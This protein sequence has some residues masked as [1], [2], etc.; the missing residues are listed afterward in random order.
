MPPLTSDALFFL[1]RLTCASELLGQMD[2][3]CVAEKVQRI[4]SHVEKPHAVRGRW[5][6]Y[7]MPPL[8]S[9]ALSVALR[10]LRVGR[11]LKRSSLTSA[12]QSVPNMCSSREPRPPVS[13]AD[14]HLRRLPF[15]RPRLMV[16][17]RRLVGDQPTLRI[18]GYCVETRVYGCP[19]M[20]PAFLLRTAL[21]STAGQ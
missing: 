21:M 17:Y 14:W 12:L 15:K 1:L 8:T 4:L 9:D 7:L 5:D 13:G 18:G 10:V 6:V 16:N 3:I 19:V 11:F 20:L 2:R